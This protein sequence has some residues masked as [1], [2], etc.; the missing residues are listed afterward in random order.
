ME[1]NRKIVFVIF[2]VK[3]IEIDFGTDIYQSRLQIK[4]KLLGVAK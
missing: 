1:L 3:Q 4:K 2:N